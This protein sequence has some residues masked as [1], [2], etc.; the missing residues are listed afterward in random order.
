M[1]SNNSKPVYFNNIKS[2]PLLSN[3]DNNEG[4]N[5]RDPENS[6]ESDGQM[7]SCMPSLNNRGKLINF[8]LCF[9]L[10]MTHL[11]KKI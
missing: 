9:F 8:V 1:S 11:S 10:G 3:D 5:V 2:Y 7:Q 6:E 4:D